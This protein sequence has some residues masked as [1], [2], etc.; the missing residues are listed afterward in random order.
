[1]ETLGAPRLQLLL[2]AFLLN[3]H[4]EQSRRQLAFTF[5]PDS[6]EKQAQTNLRNLLHL[7]RGALPEAERFLITDTHTLRWNTETPFTLDVIQ[8]LKIVELAKGAQDEESK[9]KLLEKAVGMYK[10]ELLP[11]FYEE[12]ILVK[13][14]HLR[15]TYRTA[16]QDLISGLE[17]RR[18]Y[19]FALPF[20]NRLIELDPLDESAYRTLMRLYA[21][22]LDR[23]SALRTYHG[24]ASTL[25]RELGVEPSPTTQDAY[26][27]LLNLAEGPPGSSQPETTSQLPLIGRRI[28]WQHLLSA[29]T[30]A[31]KHKPSLALVSGEPGIGKSRLAAELRQWVERQGVLSAIAQCYPAEGQLPYAP[32]AAWLKAERIQNGLSAIEPVWRQEIERLLPR[33]QGESDPTETVQLRGEKWQRLRLFE[34]IAR[35]LLAN[36]SPRLFLIEDLQWCDR[37][38]LEFLHFLLRFDPHASLMVAGTARLEEADPQHPLMD[39]IHSLRTEKQLDEFPLSSLSRTESEELAAR[40]LGDKYDQGVGEK[41]FDETEGNP[42]F[43]IETIRSGN[44]PDYLETSDSRSK[45]APNIQAVLNYRLS[46][47]T[48]PARELA[49]LAAV[50]GREFRVRVL[51]QASDLDETSLIRT[52]DELWRKKIFR[53]QGLDGYDFSHIK[54]REAAYQNLSQV[55]KRHYHGKIARAL[56]TAGENNIS[57]EYGIIAEH[58]NRA[59]ENAQ[60]IRYYQRAAQ[61]AQKLFANHKGISYCQR[62]LDLM[63]ANTTIPG[64]RTEYPFEEIQETLGDLWQR[65]GEYGKATVAYEQ[66]LEAVPASRAIA[67]S[68]LRRKT[69]NTNNEQR[70]YKLADINFLQAENE[71]GKKPAKTHSAWWQAWL[72][73]QLDRLSLYYDQARMAEM[74]ALVEQVR[75]ILKSLGK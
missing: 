28:E 15:Q 69:A 59:G 16:L 39:L 18:A 65:I 24:C 73:I 44:Y 67:R 63:S 26:R 43:L 30:K 53:E 21:L 9:S 14:E 1:M 55:R 66:A 5:W 58:F 11:G 17:R 72:D 75:P 3:E 13:R 42:L 49:E 64:S 8:F 29:W 27:Q 47:L 19:E 48:P 52:L 71:L 45:L 35:C 62:A 46:Q 7:L 4:L 70:K 6:T 2:A 23:S 41:L 38:T 34:A 20:A 61:A 31:A 10:G 33:Y 22:N 36:S 51:S 32:L 25:A 40:L 12:W 50:L 74:Q 37:E 68:R 54:L 60:A 57:N 56:E